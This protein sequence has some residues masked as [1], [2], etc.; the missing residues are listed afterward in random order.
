MSTPLDEGDGIEVSITISEPGTYQSV[1]YGVSTTIRPGESVE[2]T[3]KR[4]EDF[5]FK[6]AV[7]IL[8]ELNVG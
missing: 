1:R 3:Q 7:R 5:V 6:H 4:A 2:E 8:E